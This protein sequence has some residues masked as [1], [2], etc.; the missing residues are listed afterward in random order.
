MDAKRSSH[1]RG[2]TLIELLIVVVIIGILA[3]IAIPKFSRVREK[4]YFAAMKADLRNL[5]NIEDVYYNDNYTYT[6]D[7]AALGF[8]NT[9]GVTVSIGVATNTGWSASATHSAL[10]TGDACAIFHG[11]APA[12]SPA[13]VVSVVQCNR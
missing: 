2:F 11:S 13:T 4:A 9:E 1:A 8:T 7:Q 10:A 12:L 5:A 6:S 3:S